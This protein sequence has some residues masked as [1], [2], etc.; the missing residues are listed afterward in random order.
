MKLRSFGI[1]SFQRLSVWITCPNMMTFVMYKRSEEI[2]SFV[3]LFCLNLRRYVKATPL[4]PLMNNPLLISCSWGQKSPLPVMCCMCWLLKRK[5][6][7]EWRLSPY[8][9][10]NGTIFKKTSSPWHEVLY[11]FM[12]TKSFFSETSSTADWRPEYLSHRGILVDF[13]LW[14]RAY[15]V[16]TSACE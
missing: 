14:C 6:R 3:V 15:P 8:R 13:A 5:K 11:W 16:N 9:I 4:D 7:S 1:L 10:S 12:M 2:Q